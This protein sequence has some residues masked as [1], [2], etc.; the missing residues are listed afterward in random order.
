MIRTSDIAE[1]KSLLKNI[2][3]V[4]ITS[5]KGA[6]V[7][8]NKDIIT[9]IDERFLALPEDEIY[10]YLDIA[11][12]IFQPKQLDNKNIEL[13]FEDME[14]DAQKILRA[15]VATGLKDESMLENFYAKVIEDYSMVGNFL[16]LLYHDTYDVMKRTSDGKELDE[17]EEVYEHIICVICPVVLDKPGL[18]YDGADNYIRP[19]GRPWIVQKPAAGFVYPAFEDRSANE[20][21]VL[22]YC[23]KPKEPAHELIECVLECKPVKT[24]AEIQEEFEDMVHREVE[25]AELTEDFLGKINAVFQEMLLEE[26]VDYGVQPKRLTD[27]ELLSIAI[28]SGIPEHYAQKIAKGYARM[29]Y[30]EW[31][32]LEWLFNQKMCTM[33]QAK[34]HKNKMRNLLARA[35]RALDQVRNRELVEEIDI[36]LERNRQHGCRCSW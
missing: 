36:Y 31:P 11:K 33:E 10:K 5:M 2:G 29:V 24:A 4:T 35:G 14:T 20:D 26:Q 13:E 12:E 21:K 17:S 19:K 34:Q 25:S 30:S 27:L 23:A 16:I 7:S 18:Q 28:K 9:R 32:K 15:L 1:L 22:Y 3:N 8:A 6:Y